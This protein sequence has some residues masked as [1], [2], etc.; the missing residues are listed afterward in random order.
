[1]KA[2]KLSKSRSVFSDIAYVALNAGLA[3][4]IL[5]VV[6]TMKSPMLAFALVLLGKW[7]I[8]AVRPRFW[9]KNIRSNMVDIIVG[10]S[11]VVLL[12]A[13]TG[14]LAVQIAITVLYALWL[15]VIKPKSKRQYAIIQAGVA[16]FIG[17]NALF[18]VS[19]SWPAPLVVLLMWVIGYTTA[20]HIFSHYHEE[21]RNLFSMI[22]ALV[23]AEIGWLGYHWGFA[24]PM[25]GLPGFAIS[26][27]ALIILMIGFLMGRVYD[28]YH[29]NEGS[30]RASDVTL[31]A[32]LSVSVIMVV[33]IFFNTL[34]SVLV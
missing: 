16:L 18:M 27:T 8:L 28:S 24:Y 15:I 4:A 21:D 11:A 9:Y 5:L 10:L 1:M 32:V 2:I 7:R 13:T 34:G 29:V 22:W 19:H 3:V 6:L 20:R 31:P 12:Q 17:V 33:M 26:Q 23:V 14:A 25:P 30:I